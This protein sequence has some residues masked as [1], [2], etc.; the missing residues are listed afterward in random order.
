[1]G[2]HRDKDLHILLAAASA[3][4]Q[5]LAG[6]VGQAVEPRRI[7]EAHL[8]LPATVAEALLQPRAEP[9]VAVGRAAPRQRLVAVL[10]PELAPGQPGAAALA[11]RLEFFDDRIRARY[12]CRGR[13]HGSA[14]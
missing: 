9:A 12:R 5:R 8:R 7:V 6:E 13:R 10:D 14:A 11:R 4:R 2:Q 1:M 3:Q